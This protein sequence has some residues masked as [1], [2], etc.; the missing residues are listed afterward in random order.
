MPFDI[1]EFQRTPFEARTGEVKIPELAPWFGGAEPVFVVRGLTGIEMAQCSESAGASRLRAELV[2][3][4]IDGSN[5]ERVHALLATF[6]LSEDVPGELVRYHELIIRGTVEP[7]IDRET[8][9]LL[10]ERFPV[11]HRA[12]ALQIMTLSGQGQVCKKKPSGSTETPE[13]A[14]P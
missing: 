9:V 7:K 13:S 3:S 8:S 1:R 14:P 4:L 2:E 6:G 12:L 10:A 11:D 5:Q